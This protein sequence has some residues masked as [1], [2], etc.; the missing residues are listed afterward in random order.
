MKNL[1]NVC[2]LVAFITAGLSAM[3][4]FGQGFSTWIWQVVVMIWIAT[5]YLKQKQIDKLNK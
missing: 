2:M 3:M 4:F 1:E 5:C